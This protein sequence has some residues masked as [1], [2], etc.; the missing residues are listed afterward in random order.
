MAAMF[1][2]RAPQRL[3]LGLGLACV[4]ITGG[5]TTSSAT[6]T[7][8]PQTNLASSDPAVPVATLGSGSNTSTSVAPE[9]RGDLRGIRWHACPT[10]QVATLM[11]GTLAVPYDYANPAGPKFVLAV[12]KVPALGRKVGTLFF[13]PGGPGGAGAASTG[14]AATQMPMSVREKFDV[15]GWDPRGIGDTRPALQGCAQPQPVLPATGP[16]DW[17]LARSRTAAV[18]AAA[19]RACQQRNA[20]FINFMGTNNVA[21]DLDRLRAAVGDTKLTYWAI[22]YGTR[23]GY[24]YALM[25]PTKIRAMV[26]D[27]NI[28]PKGDYAGLTQGGVALDSALSFMK[29]ASPP[30]YNSIMATVNSL[31]AKPVHLGKGLS[32]TRWNYLTDLTGAI[33]SEASWPKL[34]AANKRI[35]N[36]GLN[37]PE[38]AAER[39]RMR[40]SLGYSD[41]NLGGA[42]S[43]INCLDY[44]DRMTPA[45]Q[46]AVINANATIGPV[47]GGKITTE[48][49]LGCE[50]L[51]LRPDPVPLTTSA[52]SR[53]RIKSIPVVIANATNDGSTP[54]FWAQRM[55]DSFANGVFVKYRG[56]QHALW[57]STP[58]AC[59]NNRITDY[60]LSLKRPTPV[61]CPFAPPPGL[62][63]RG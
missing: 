38:A 58:S 21:R 46:N 40:R 12:A 44:A 20:S 49:A 8:P 13:D 33:P 45:A 54:I 32:Y 47:Y 26:L 5:A 61:L 4:V 16:V 51:R 48:Y 10:E 63:R 60:F 22:S 25:Y 23:I 14:W 34:I 37:T 50:G 43:V 29:L 17:S 62:P 9:P 1:P 30:T 56:A 53:S 31:A 6:T 57:T 28:D 41:E 2:G 27:G 18:A 39:A 36:A 3:T 55:R 24:V 15:V 7:P 59:V 42:F 52:A 35:L 11:C 19:N